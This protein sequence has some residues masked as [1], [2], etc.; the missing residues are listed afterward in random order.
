MNQKHNYVPRMSL[1]A[2]ALAQAFATQAMAQEAPADANTVVVTGIRASAQSSVAIKRNAMEVVDS[3]TADDIGKLPDPNVAETLTRLP[4]VQGYRYGGEGA[5]P[6][7]SGS[8]LAIRGLM[9]QTASQVNGRAYFTAG[10]RE[11]NIED[12]IPATIA[13]VDV[14]KNPSA[15]HIEG[16]IGGL[17]NIRTRNP[18]DFKGFTASLNANMRYN[19]LVKKKE[20]ELF[21]LVANRFDLGGGSRI[22][23][24]AAVAYQKTTGRMDQTG[25]GTG[26]DYR[27]MV[28]GDSA[29]Y[30]TKAAAN[31]SNNPTLP[32]SKYVGRSDITYLAPVTLLPTSATVGAQTPNTAGL[33]P[34]EVAN[35]I[36]FTGA[37]P[38]PT[39]ETIMRERKGMNLAADYRVDNTLRFY[40]ESNYNR[41]VY[42]QNYRFSRFMTGYGGNVQNLTL[43]PFAIT[44]SMANRNFNGGSDDVLSSQRV[45]SGTFLNQQIGSWGGD[46]RSPY[47]TWNVATGAE[48]KPTSSLSLK[49]DVSYIK[50]DRIKDNRRVEMTNAPNVFYTVD[51]VNENWTAGHLTKVTGDNGANVS[52]PA[53][54]VFQKYNGDAY[55]V[56]D[57]NG[58]AT[59]LNGIYTFEDGFFSRLKFGT[60]FAHQ[61]NRYYDKTPYA[62]GKWLTTDGKP[63]AA[64]Y[65]NAIYASSKAGSMEQIPSN[66]LHNQN[67]Y[68]GGYVVYKSDALLGNQVAEQFP[69]SG[70]A[71]EGSYPENQLARRFLNENTTAGYVS[72]DFAAFDD[73]LKGNV[74]VRVVRT[75]SVATA[76][77]LSDATVPTSPIIDYTKSTTYTNVLPALNATYDISN[78]FLVRVGYGKGITRPG[79]DQLNPNI[80]VNA[81]NGTA[82]LGNPDL[83][84]QTAD[85]Y[86][87]S[88]ERYFSP[89]NFVALGLF[90]KK[91]DGFFSSLASCVTVPNA[92]PYAGGISN[93]C[94]SGQYLISKTVNAAKGYAR[95]AELSGQWFFNGTDSWYK[96]FG[97]AGSYTYVDTLA[98]LNIGTAAAPVFIKTQ[99]NFVSKNSYSLTG[100]YEDKKLSARLVYTW[101]SS[102]AR[103]YNALSP[104]SSTY[105]A[106]YGLLDASLSYAI[107]EHLTLSA[108]ASNLTN[109]A[110]NRYTGEVQT[111]E[112]DREY[113]HVDN[114]RVF[115]LGLRYKF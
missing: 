15:E 14:Y 80:S 50:A 91:I 37:G 2:L 108:N 41:Y 16:A 42:H 72:G 8:G 31:T 51:R 67:G 9:G 76:R 32:M 74:G 56:Y 100:M 62:G 52:N 33:T 89:T 5:S 79:I 29:E 96:N 65:S 35:I 4:G 107:D 26:A 102:E 39:E 40:A 44:E 12:A 54:Y 28:R 38:W 10:S 82:N 75:K 3:I 101:R 43:A 22:G 49:A 18:S 73:R 59:A 53:N 94:S 13:G 27:R 114:G 70:I 24:L 90:D 55:N 21:G 63:L 83:R 93:G 110:N 85:S 36:S 11:F 23:V 17:V 60:R 88:F 71:L 47:T 112:T 58:A 99:Q 19:D 57:D 25:G 6:G 1:V 61:T 7:G 78:D 34:A 81:S 95:G 98:P 64:D 115:S 111:L 20:P 66:L 84:P 106:D 45:H 104:M 77:V 86:D 109:K 113:S 97:V 105:I 69:Q 87:L 103:T 46:D 92:A 48:W 68:T 30:A